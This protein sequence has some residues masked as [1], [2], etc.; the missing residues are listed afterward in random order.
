MATEFWAY[1]GATWREATEIWAYDGATWR[2][3]ATV[4]AYDGA[5]WRLVFTS[6]PAISACTFTF[7]GG[8]CGSGIC[9]IKEQ[10]T[11]GLTHTGCI[12]ADHHIDLF[13]KVDGGSYNQVRG[14]LVCTTTGQVLTYDY[15]RGT[16]GPETT[17][18]YKWEIQLDSD[19][20]V[21]ASC[22]TPIRT[23]LDRTACASCGA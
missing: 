5:T 19:Q 13:Q 1:D 7:S 22:E 10:H 4:Y 21:L 9:K 16:I 8:L 6:A 23:A 12:D 11:V 14:P 3:A 15:A 18:Q 17:F 2:N 20:S